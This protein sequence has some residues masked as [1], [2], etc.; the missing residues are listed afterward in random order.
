[1]LKSMNRKIHFIL[2]IL[3]LFFL[4]PVA[5]CQNDQEAAQGTI[6]AEVEVS[7]VGLYASVRDSKDRPVKGLHKEDFHLTDS[8]KPLE[9]AQ[10]SGDPD[11][12]ASVVF[13]VDTSGSM[14]AGEK[15]DI[16]ERI[17]DE[18]LKRLDSDDEASLITFGDEKVE[19]QAELTKDKTKVSNA[20]A[21]QKLYGPTALWDA[22]LYSQKIV[23]RNYGK[24]GIVLISDGFDNRSESVFQRAVKEAS[25][26]PL[27]VYVVE[28]TIP[29]DAAAREEHFDSPLKD[30]AAGTG[31]LHFD[32]SGEK[33]KEITKVAERLVEELR[34]QYYLGVPG[35]ALSATAKLQVTISNRDYTVRLRHS[36]E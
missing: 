20:L 27:P 23:I 12:A 1:M 15:Y 29:E 4:R 10:F 8:G 28:I 2:L 14:R 3:L 32:V 9:I 7:L 13:L 33:E 17:V 35:S 24:K 31:G 26:I 36:I 34:Y 16:A 5:H 11:E 30:F 25:L 22:I 21:G 19:T 18:V 6:S